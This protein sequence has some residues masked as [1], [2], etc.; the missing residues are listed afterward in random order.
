MGADVIKV[1]APGVGRPDAPVGTREADGQSLWW[2]VVGRNKRSVT[3]N[4]REEEGQELF[5]A[6][7]REVR[8]RR[9]ELP[10]R[11]PREVEPLLRAA[12]RGQPR[13]HPGPGHAATARPAPTPRAPATARSAR[14]W[15]ACATSLGDPDRQPSRAGISIGDSLAAMHA[16][17]GALAA[18]QHRERHRRGPGRRR[19]DLRVGARDDGVAGHRVGPGQGYQRER[20]GAI[21]PNVAPSNVYPTADGQLILIAA[22]QDSVFGRLVAMMGDPELVRAGAAGTPTTSAAASDQTAARRATSRCGPPRIDADEL[23][24]DAGRGWCAGRPDLQ[25]RRHAR[26]TRTS[27]RATPS[28][29]SPTRRS[30]TLAMQNVVPKLSA[31]PGSSGGPAPTLGQHNDEV[32]GDLLGLDEARRAELAASRRHLSGPRRSDYA[33]SVSAAGSAAATRPAVVVVDV[34]TA[35]LEGGPLTDGAGRFESARASTAR[36][37]DAARA[38]GHPVDLHGGQA[39]ARAAP[40]PAG[41]RS[42]CPG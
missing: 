2:P 27:R 18:L 10:R 41:S 3:L 14:P 28:S 15:A 20:T 11:H 24:D 1:E 19:V 5:L 6:A 9:R 42:R 38:A 34:V 25:G 12:A 8:H 16:T 29:G 31:T 13:P 4:L 23:L 36:V 30:A 26:R 32:Y 33:A 22:N 40:T 35:Y 37:V 7:G 39:R 17:V 21:L